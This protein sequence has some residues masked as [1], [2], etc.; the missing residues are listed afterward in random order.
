MATSDELRED[1]PA[2]RPVARYDTLA[3]QAY[4]QLRHALTTGRFLPG[5]KLTL[6][7]TAAM[8]GV[9]A[10]PARDAMSRL[11][12]ERALQIDAN[13][14]VSVPKLDVE[15]LREIYLLRRTLE[16]VAAQLGAKNIGPAEIEALERI[17]RSHIAAL[18]RNDYR[19]ALMENEAFHFYIYMASKVILLVEAIQQLWLKLGPS[20][21]LLYPSY[22][23]SRRGVSHHLEAIRHLRSGDATAVRRSIE[24]DLRDGGLELERAIKEEA[25]GAAPSARK[26]ACEAEPR[27]GRFRRAPSD[28]GKRSRTR[29]PIQ[30]GLSPAGVAEVRSA[31][32]R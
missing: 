2:I 17:Q 31:R 14:S 5:Q 12:S 19:T 3:D 15:Q 23:H 24:R 10:T 4:Q 30:P 25:S 21:N 22:N 16:G 20:L 6:R 11:V 1:G 18:D 13:R 8:L 7:R 26:A 28:G 32:P 29:T 9:S 27:A